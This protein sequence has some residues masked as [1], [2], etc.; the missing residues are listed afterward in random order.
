[1]ISIEGSTKPF[2]AFLGAILSEIKGVSVQPSTFDPHMGLD[3]IAEQDEDRGSLSG[4]DI[5]DGSGQ[6][7]GSPSKGTATQPRLTRRRSR[8]GYSEPD[9][10]VRPSLHCHLLH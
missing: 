1:M 8:D 6:Y 9:L 5:S 7:G 10:M 4:G 3:I 2:R